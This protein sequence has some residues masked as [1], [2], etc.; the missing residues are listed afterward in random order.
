MKN[1]EINKNRVGTA[2]SYSSQ[3]ACRQQWWQANLSEPNSIKIP[4][5]VMDYM[6]GDRS[7]SAE[8]YFLWHVILGKAYSTEGWFIWRNSK[9]LAK[10][11]N[12]T[13]DTLIK[14]LKQLEETSYLQLT[15][16]VPI[17]SKSLFK[18]T[19]SLPED[20]FELLKAAPNINAQ[21]RLGSA[22]QGGLV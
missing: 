17:N 16:R 18:I 7:I 5:V 10:E 4:V 15:P 11:T 2:G 6:L 3:I 13:V 19:I 14:L 9:E 8:S 20:L 22:S 21:S 12:R 1:I